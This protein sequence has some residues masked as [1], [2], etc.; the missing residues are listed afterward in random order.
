MQSIH[1]KV[2]ARNS[3]RRFAL[4]EPKFS[5]LHQQVAAVFGLEGNNW[6]VKYKDEENTLVT[7]S[8]DE[9]LA[10]AVQLMGSLLHIEIIER[11]VQANQKPEEVHQP[12]AKNSE[13][14]DRVLAHLTKKHANIS[15]RL[16]VLKTA[17]NPKQQAQVPKLEQKLA[18]IGAR[19]ADLSGV[20]QKPVTETAPIE[21]TPIPSPLPLALVPECAPAP[22]FNQK[23]MRE[24]NGKFQELRRNFQK[25]QKRIQSLV[26]VVQAMKVISKHGA[27]AA[28]PVQI[29]D[30]Q[31][32]LAQ[33]S[34]VASKQDLSSMKE[35]L[36][37]QAE[38]VK[39]LHRQKNEYIKGQKKAKCNKQANKVHKKKSCEELVKPADLPEI[40]EAPEDKNQE[41]KLKRQVTKAQKLE[42]KAAKVALKAERQALKV[43][44]QE[45][46][47]AK[48]AERAQIQE[49]K[50]RRQLAKQST[51]DAP[52]LEV[53][54]N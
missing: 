26:A 21:A 7:I 50:R 37:K 32:Q 45:E 54:Q 38:L 33:A 5:V 17:E 29:N 15:A 46:K 30:E 51:E 39:Q 25:E 41:E 6:V 49:E 28:A 23:L 9:E 16:S 22:K 12:R 53:A 35:Q 44:R 31:A 36:K 10:F 8:S 2:T 47:V 19:I 52:V 20:P 40:V 1:F 34:L 11:Q 3:I 13:N 14:K 43:K 4:N 27:K 48:Q 18:D 42:E 24:A